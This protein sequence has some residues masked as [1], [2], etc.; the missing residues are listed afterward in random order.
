MTLR[1]VDV[2]DLSL[3]SRVRGVIVCL[4]GVETLPRGTVRID[5]TLVQAGKRWR[6]AGRIPG[7]E[8]P[9]KGGDIELLV[10]GEGKPVEGPC[11]VEAAS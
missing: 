10:A 1:I 7:G 8:P 9:P 11:S 2:S 6:I 5:A 3:G 4:A